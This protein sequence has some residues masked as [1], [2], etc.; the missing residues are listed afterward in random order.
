MRSFM[1][2]LYSLRSDGY[3]KAMRIGRP[4]HIKNI[5]NAGD[6]F[7]PL[8]TK[9]RSCGRAFRIIAIE[10]FAS[11]A[12]YGA[13]SLDCMSCGE[14]WTDSMEELGTNY[15]ARSKPQRVALDAAEL[16]L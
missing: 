1:A 4:F 8:R 3:T 5:E 9:C 15:G 7:I 16:V 14:Y 10:V 2:P 12:L 13:R 6:T 11:Q